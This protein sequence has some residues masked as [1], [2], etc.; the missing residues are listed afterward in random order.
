[1]IKPPAPFVGTLKTHMGFVM[2][3][4]IIAFLIISTLLVGCQ[5]T[6][7]RLVNTWSNQNSSK[8]ISVDAGICRNEAYR[9]VPQ[10]VK[11]PQPAPQQ[12]AQTGTYVVSD[13]YGNTIGTARANQPTT[14]PDYTAFSRGFNS[15]RADHAKQ[16][17]YDGQIKR[18]LHSCLRGK[19]WTLVKQEWVEG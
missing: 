5:T 16:Q 8:V 3:L 6:H 4:Q 13:V 14:S 18:Y 17:A 12:Q 7:K 9:A 2:N 11:T 10:P 1:M 19:G 15:A